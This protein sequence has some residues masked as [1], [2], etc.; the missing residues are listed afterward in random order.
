MKK[1]TLILSLMI[2]FIFPGN[3]LI[4]QDERPDCAG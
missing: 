4:A 1:S 3:N 2:A